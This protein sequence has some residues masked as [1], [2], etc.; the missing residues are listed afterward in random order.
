[1]V[2]LSSYTHT[3]HRYHHFWHLNGMEV[4]TIWTSALP[5]SDGLVSGS[6]SSLLVTWAIARW[7]KQEMCVW[8]HMQMQFWSFQNQPCVNCS[9][10]VEQGGSWGWPSELYD[11]GM[12]A[13]PRGRQS[14]CGR[15]ICRLWQTRSV[16]W[17]GLGK[18]T[19]KGAGGSNEWWEWMILQGRKYEI[20]VKYSVASSPYLY[21]I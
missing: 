20:Y 1:M 13:P 3:L 8:I 14:S 17:P 9:G 18:P 4:K 6:D 16:V 2:P 12:E 21:Q 15:A 7:L 10:A 11:A 19:H 5:S